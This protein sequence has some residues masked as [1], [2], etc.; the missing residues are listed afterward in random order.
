M[1][2]LNELMNM[3]HKL[4][5]SPED[6]F[7]DYKTDAKVNN[8]LENIS[9]VNLF[10]GANNSGKSRFLRQLFI[11]LYFSNHSNINRLKDNKIHCTFYKV[12]DIKSIVSDSVN[13]LNEVLK[14]D[15]SKQ[16]LDQFLEEFEETISKKVTEDLDSNEF[17]KLV[18]YCVNKLAEVSNI[19]L[20]EINISSSL[21]KPKDKDH[22]KIV[23]T[24]TKKI[25]KLLS[26]LIPKDPL[27]ETVLSYIPPIRTL[28][29]FIKFKLHEDKIEQGV[30]THT[31][32]YIEQPIIKEKITL[33]YFKECFPGSFKKPT[34]EFFR[35]ELNFE[36][37]ETGEDLYEKIHF[38]RNS[39]ASQRKRLSEF[40]DFLS[41][42]FFQGKPVE[43]NAINDDG[44]EE[45]F[46]KIG[47]EE[48][49]PIHKLGDGIQAIIILT[50]TLFKNKD[51]EQ[52]VFYEEPELYL[53]PGFQRILINC[54]VNIPNL[55]VFIA[56]HSNHLLDLTLE[57]PNQFS[58]YSF[59]KVL[60]K[61][62]SSFQIENLSSPNNRILDNLGV[63]NSSVF[64]SNCTIWVEGI[65]DKIYLRNALSLFFEKHSNKQFKED[66]HYS[67]VEYGGNNLLHWNFEKESEKPSNAF[68][69]SNR[70]FL[71]SDL[72]SDKDEKHDI[73]KDNLDKNYYPLNCLE[74]ENL[75]TVDVLKSTLKDYKLDSTDKLDFSEFDY[76]D[77]KLKPIGEFIYEVVDKE[78]IKKLASTPKKNQTGKIY[79]KLDFAKTATNHIKRWDDLSDEAQLLTKRIVEFIEYNN[80]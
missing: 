8:R 15:S 58:I 32:E 40:E 33:D 68:S 1:K 70:I 75:L 5:Y 47:Q 62:K 10:V 18:D 25:D 27:V 37:I 9:K 13:K 67:F 3:L 79:N 26:K 66:L 55:Q 64:L 34:K 2:V 44:R 11:S 61:S 43:I 54:F 51:K 4:S 50:F 24:N 29:K 49:F 12:S 77:Y 42:N 59:T 30:Y 63:R 60:H 53:H 74:I 38:L 7:K 22:Y 46:I 36:N 80:Q 19:E 39:R 35:D 57:Y 23:S 6:T 71:I 31:Y 17:Q 45:I 69:L 72:D 20:S 28:K 56:T 76:E 14:K 73:L 21:T 41:D 65:S 48:E 78:K 52:I 16:K